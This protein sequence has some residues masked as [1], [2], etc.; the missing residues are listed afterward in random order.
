MSKIDRD[1]YIDGE[2]SGLYPADQKKS[3]E[4]QSNGIT[5]Y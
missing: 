3:I 2:N 4:T 1:C 5:P